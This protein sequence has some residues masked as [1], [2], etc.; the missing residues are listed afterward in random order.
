MAWSLRPDEIGVEDLLVADDGDREHRQKREQRDDPHFFAMGHR[1][2]RGALTLFDNRRIGR[3][4]FPAGEI[5]R[6]ADQHADAGGAEAVVPAIHFAERAGDERRG[7]D[8]AV[9]EQI[10][11]LEGISA[12]IVA[13]GIKRADLAG[14]VAL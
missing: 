12:P 10:V 11:N 7:D 4:I 2:F 9:D 1:C 3:K 5:N 14:E 8:T 13:G 6:Q